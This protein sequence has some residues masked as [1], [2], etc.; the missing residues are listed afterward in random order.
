VTSPDRQ[1]STAIG[2]IFFI[3]DSIGYAAGWYPGGVAKTTD[4]G[5][6]WTNQFMGECWDVFFTDSQT[7]YV[8]GWWE[9]ISKTENGGDDWE[10]LH[11]TPSNLTQFR[12]IDCIDAN[13][14]Y[15]VGDSAKVMTTSNGADFIYETIPTNE[16]L[17]GV[18]MTDRYCYVVGKKGTIYRKEHNITSTE[19]SDNPKHQITIY[20][21]PTR[22]SAYLKIEP[23]TLQIDNIRL[24]DIAG[25]NIRQFEQNNNL[26]DLQDIP[27][28]MYLLQFEIEGRHIS[29]KIIVE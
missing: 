4:A 2:D 22:Q 28:G 16:D 3:T 29:K 9:Y 14:C 17:Y 19:E 12:A 7:G 20:P 23:S 21:N 15:V 25:K 5:N 11:N 10:D 24:V 18:D 1:F 13:N 27:T 6:T 26:I 8:V